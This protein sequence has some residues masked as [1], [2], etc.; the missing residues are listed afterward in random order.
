LQKSEISKGLK[1]YKVHYTGSKLH[2]IAGFV[3]MH[4]VLVSKFFAGITVLGLL[5]KSSYP[6]VKNMMLLYE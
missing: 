6:E 2:P 4:E 3:L 5:F 1:G